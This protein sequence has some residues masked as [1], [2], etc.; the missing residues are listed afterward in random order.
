M[1]KLFIAL[2]VVS[3]FPSALFADPLPLNGFDVRHDKIKAPVYSRLRLSY[4]PQKDENGA[5]TLAELT[6][7]NEGTEYYLIDG[8]LYMD[9]VGFTLYI[10]STKTLPRPEIID[11]WEYDN[12][13]QNFYEKTLRNFRVHPTNATQFTLSCGNGKSVLFIPQT[14]LYSKITWID[15][16]HE[17]PFTLEECP[18][19]TDYQTSRSFAYCDDNILYYDGD[20][21]LSGVPADKR[22]SGIFFCDLKNRTRGAY[23]VSPVVDKNDLWPYNPMGVPG[24]DWIIYAKQFDDGEHKDQITNQLVVRKK[25][26][27]K[28]ADKAAKEYQKRLK[29]FKKENTKK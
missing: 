10:P 11:F 21:N 20:E 27:Q 17:H 24:T 16:G 13:Y 8:H 22:V 19:S 4:Y 23:A 28:Q 1:K 18:V 9:F 6:T 26:T 2:F 12:A 5:Y 25:L 14:E 7:D 29:S 15:D 3:V